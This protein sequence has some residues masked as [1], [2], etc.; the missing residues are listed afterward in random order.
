M[1]AKRVMLFHSDAGEARSRV[2][3]LK[4]FGYG[5]EWRMVDPEVLR[6]I[7][8]KPPAA[9]VID[10]ARTPAQGRDIGIYIR[11]HK[12]TRNIPIVFVNGEAEKVTRIREH[13]PDATY[14]EWDGIKK[15]LKQAIMH[16]AAQPRVPKSLFAGYAGTPLFKKLGIKPHYV[17]VLVDAPS[18]SPSVLVD[19]PEGVV[20][21]RRMSRNNDLAIWFVRS[22]GVLNRRIKKISAVVG[23]GGLWIVW[24]KRSSGISSDLTQT[25][26][27]QAGLGAGLVDYRVCAVDQI[28]SGLKF[29]VRK[30]R[31]AVA[32]R[33]GA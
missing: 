31:C 11:H 9:F 24:P 30:K 18:N 17:V 19:L 26:V 21:Q 5:V 22:Q 28:W 8:K 29:A 14:T 27:R 3:A 15:A 23:K 13:L 32:D 1:Y 7:R 12:T 6:N 20:L 25:T 10:L 2:R 4:T 16:P 33:E